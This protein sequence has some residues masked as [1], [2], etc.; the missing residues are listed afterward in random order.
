MWLCF[1]HS[2]LANSVLC[3]LEKRWLDKCPVEFKPVFYWQYM[4]DIFVF[5]WK[6]KHFKLYLSSIRAIKIWILLPKWKPTT[7]SLFSVLKYHE[8][9]MNLSF[10]FTINP[11]LVEYFHILI[12]SFLS[13]DFNFPQPFYL[14]QYRTNDWTEDSD[15]PPIAYT[16][17]FG[18]LC[19]LC[20]IYVLWACINI[21]KRFDK[22][23]FLTSLFKPFFFF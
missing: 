21:K 6:K 13:I 17:A 5:S 2:T 3:C 7:S 11:H 20:F 15:F 19:T 23:N 18:A 14:F 1:F 9:E 16:T 10:R 8:I 22:L 12:V 4:D